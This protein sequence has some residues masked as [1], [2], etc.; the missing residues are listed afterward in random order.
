MKD[1]LQ[2]SPAGANGSDP[3]L[4]LNDLPAKGGSVLSV[5]PGLALGF[6]VALCKEGKVIWKPSSSDRLGGEG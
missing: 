4:I 3:V 5:E 1:T 6:F 2:R